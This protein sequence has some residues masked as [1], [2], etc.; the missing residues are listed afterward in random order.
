[1]F[2]HGLRRAD[3]GQVAFTQVI[4]V[5]RMA[6]DLGAAGIAAFGVVFRES[7]I[8]DSAVE[9]LESYGVPKDQLMALYQSQPI[10]RSAAFQRVLADAGAYRLAQKTVQ[11]KLSK[12][13]PPVQSPGTAGSFNR[14]DNMAA[15][16]RAF[17][18][19]PSPQNAAAVLTAKRA[20]SRR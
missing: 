13:V 17:D 7:E 19:N 9:L 18:K 3:E 12:P 14:D 11:E 5:D 6:R 4:D 15:A 10:M 20:A 1:M 8:A 16:L 2:D